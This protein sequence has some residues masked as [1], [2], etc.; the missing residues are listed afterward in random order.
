MSGA[1]APRKR[2]VIAEDDPSIAA[3]L[4]KVLR[5][6]YDL[7]LVHDGVAAVREA[8]KDPKPALLLLDVMMPGLDGLGVAHEVRKVAELKNVPIIFLTAK[9]GPGDVIK[10]IQSG[11]RHY[12]SKPF[13]IDDV[14]SKVKKAI[15]G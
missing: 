12:I 7:T 8:K 9:S 15:G 4:D 1:Q 10:G 11:A 2:I 6:L 13:K 3:M 5:P 14:L